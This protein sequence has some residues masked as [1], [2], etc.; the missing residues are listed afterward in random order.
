MKFRLTCLFFGE[1]VAELKSLLT[2]CDADCVIQVLPYDVAIEALSR[3]WHLIGCLAEDDRLRNSD[4]LGSTSSRS[5]SVWTQDF[6][7]NHGKRQ[8]LPLLTS[9]ARIWTRLLLSLNQST[10]SW[11]DYTFLLLFFWLD[12]GTSIFEFLCSTRYVHRSSHQLT[13]PQSQNSH[14]MKLCP[15]RTLR[16]AFGES[17]CIPRS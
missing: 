3:I 10:E 17:V 11:L 6:D 9:Q 14:T 4:T 12:C 1:H 2:S 13:N 7:N 16:S 15:A 8:P 5:R